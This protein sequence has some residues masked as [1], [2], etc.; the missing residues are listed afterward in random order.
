MRT[1]AAILLIVF[2]V[3]NA[4]AARLKDLA[5]IRGVRSNQLVGY[6][7]VVGLS[8][9]GDDQQVYFTLRS[10]Q[11]M[12][13]RLGVQAAE[14]GVFDLRNLR[15]RNSAAVMVTATL[16][17]FARAGSKIDVTVSSLGNAATLQGGTLLLTP[18]RG[19]D[20]K[21]YSLAQGALMVGGF[22]VKGQ[23]GSSVT[24]NH[25]TVA[26]IPDGAI[27]EREVKSQFIHQ[28]KIIVALNRPDFTTSARLAAAI[29]RKIGATMAHS[30]DPATI[31]VRVPPE[32]KGN[33]VELLATIEMVQV[34]P[35]APAQVVINERTGTVIVGQAVRLSPVAISHGTLTLE[36][37]ERFRVSQ[38]RAPFGEGTTAIVPESNIKVEE[39]SSGLRLLK[40]GASLANVVKALNALGASPRDL[41]SIFQS[42]VEAGALPAKLVV[43]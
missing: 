36:V 5:S 43:Q 33:P 23:S 30:T 22:T 6:G 42:L 34:E 1:V 31:A 39:K 18:L 20:L 41:I 17:P 15:M 35:D 40:G 29:N 21:V 12:L 9:T 13:R 3:A 24:K 11:L 27:I 32:Y 7:L 38:P 25:P 10:V 28:D 26:R 2:T 8:G 37:A 16:P 19:V 4:H 14:E